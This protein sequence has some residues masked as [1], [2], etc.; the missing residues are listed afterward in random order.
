[1]D[2]RLQPEVKKMYKIL[3]ALIILSGCLAQDESPGIEG[4]G[5]NKGV[6]L[7]PE[8]T[9]D[10][11]GTEELGDFGKIKNLTLVSKE[12]KSSEGEYS[13]FQAT[14]IWKGEKYR[15]GTLNRAHPDNESELPIYPP[16]AQYKRAFEWIKENTP[17]DALF[18]SWWDYGDL[19]RIFAE[20]E[21]L[22]SDPCRSMKCLDTLSDDEIDVFRYEDDEKFLD[23]QKF[24]TTN[25]DEAYRIAKKYGADYVFITYEEFS[26]SYA[27]NYI[28][29]TQPSL[30]NF[31]VPLTG[32]RE[33]DT[34]NI[35]EALKVH[36][37]GAYF[38]KSIGDKHVTWYI[39]PQDVA[40]IKE[41]MLPRLLP[42]Q[43][44]PGNEYARELLENFELV[45]SD[46]EEYIYIYKII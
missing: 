24:F 12:I 25:E 27:I 41:K 5:A 6:A 35:V 11:I 23:V 33:Q 13:I 7:P 1:M 28:A 37:V 38:F 8:V 40:K 46:E 9:I 42:L 44:L 32:D 4:N 39:Q 43:I 10:I 22:V 14:Y 16:G 31:Q 3:V 29:G 2:F 36:K 26:K 30:R 21:A 15:T 19:I 45:Y 18:I 20:R 34:K 17:E